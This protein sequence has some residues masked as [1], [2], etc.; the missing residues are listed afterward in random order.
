[1]QPLACAAR[2]P[3]CRPVGLDAL[4]LGSGCEALRGSGIAS[5][6]S[7]RSSGTCWLHQS[8]IYV[9]H[10]AAAVAKLAEVCADA[11]LAEAL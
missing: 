4:G 9:V 8:A 3:S 1:M 7:G 10:I 5:P 6:A 11:E 2:A